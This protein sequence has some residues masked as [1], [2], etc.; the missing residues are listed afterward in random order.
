MRAAVLA[1][2]SLM[3]GACPRSAGQAIR[4]PALQTPDGR[5]QIV[6][7]EPLGTS[8]IRATVTISP[9][10]DAMQAASTGKNKVAPGC[11]GWTL[12]QLD[13]KAASPVTRQDILFALQSSARASGVQFPT[14]VGRA[15]AAALLDMCSKVN[16][17]TMASGFGDILAPMC[18]SVSTAIGLSVSEWA[19][20]GTVICGWYQLA[21]AKNKATL[22]TP[23]DDINA[24][25]PD[26]APVAG[27]GLYVMVGSQGGGQ[28]GPVDVR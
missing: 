1:A 23:A 14:L 15:K 21:H 6:A 28:V 2:A 22:P 3:M 13:I 24:L 18:T 11:R 10:P 25:I 20:S 16:P 7:A 26:T 17:R 8:A 19:F 4:T 27:S 9:Q 12:Y 5:W